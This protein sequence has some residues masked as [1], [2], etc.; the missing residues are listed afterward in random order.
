MYC[1]QLEVYVRCFCARSDGGRC[2]AAV[3][4]VKVSFFS[5]RRLSR[6][7]SSFYQSAFFVGVRVLP[8]GMVKGRLTNSSLRRRPLEGFIVLGFVGALW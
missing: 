6:E 3:V 1:V 2:C 4:K 7:G 5:A 8:P